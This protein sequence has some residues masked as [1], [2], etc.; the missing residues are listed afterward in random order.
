MRVALINVRDQSIHIDLLGKL[1]AVPHLRYERT[2]EVRQPQSFKHV[3]RFET[4]AYPTA[5]AFGR[6]AARQDLQQ[7]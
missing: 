4:V 6:N 3:Q 7:C 5:E 1:A 2:K